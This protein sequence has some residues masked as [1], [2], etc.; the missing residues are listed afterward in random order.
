MGT[1][2]TPE[3]RAAVENV[4]RNIRTLITANGVSYELGVDLIEVLSV[5]LMPRNSDERVM[6]VKVP[7]PRSG[8]CNEA[9]PLNAHDEEGSWCG[10]GCE[11]SNDV[12][13]S[14]VSPGDGCPWYEEER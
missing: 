12:F 7:R 10:A 1:R 13:C 9:C 5:M 6:V 2:I 11:K 8:Y 4:Q 3:Q 14:R